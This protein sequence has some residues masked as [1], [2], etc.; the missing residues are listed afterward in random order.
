MHHPAPGMAYPPPPIY[1]GPPPMALPPPPM[2]HGYPG[3]LGPPPRARS[4]SRAG[5]R[6][7]RGGAKDSKDERTQTVL[8][9]QMQKTRLCDFHKEGRCKYGSECAFAHSE[10]ELR[11]MPD[12]R[13]T[14]LCRAFTQGKCKEVDCKFA[15]GTEELRTTDLCYKT[16]L[17][18]WWDKGICQSGAQ[19]RFAHGSKDLRADDRAQAGA[20]QDGGE[21]SGDPGEGGA[22]PKAQPKRR[23]RNRPG[24][25]RR[26][27]K[28]VGML[29]AAAKDAKT[30]WIPEARAQ[31]W[32]A[33]TQVL[34]TG[35]GR[36]RDGG[37]PRRRVLVVSRPWPR[38]WAT[39]SAR[40]ARCE[41]QLYGG[42]DA[43]I[44]VQLY[45]GRDARIQVQLY[46]G[47]DAR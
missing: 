35:A 29:S 20:S 18:A 39:L 37:S 28:R 2:L 12:L 30:T 16:A 6:K 34:R 9:K 1:M 25:L 26:L 10:E 21:R 31:G 15:H 23:L 19:C 4:S 13:K 47:R 8:S 27:R 3:M 40:F 32:P 22:E 24:I 46:G 43:R 36:G 5:R 44:Q 45:G 11:D 17:C 33:A 41:G 38:T 7:T 14:R 42:R